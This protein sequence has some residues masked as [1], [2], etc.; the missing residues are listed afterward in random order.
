MLLEAFQMSVPSCLAHPNLGILRSQ[1]A[2]RLIGIQI[3]KQMQA[4]G[5]LPSLAFGTCLPSCATCLPS[6]ATC[7]PPCGPC[8]PSCGTCYP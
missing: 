3:A 6:C 8:L 7:L 4:S 2:G 1:M 5:K